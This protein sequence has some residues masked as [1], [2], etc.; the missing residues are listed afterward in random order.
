MAEMLINNV[1]QT[2][3]DPATAQTYT[4]DDWEIFAAGKWNGDAY[5][6]SD[7]DDIVQSFN[8]I[9]GKLKPYLKLGH[10]D[11]QKL[12]QK[13]GYPAAGWITGLK[14]VGEKLV[15]KVEGIPAKIYSLIQSKGYGRVSSE[16]FWNTTVEGKRYRRALKAVALLGA[17]TPE[18][19]VL[20]DFINLYTEIT[21]GELHAYHVLEEYKEVNEMD[22][23]KILEMDE[24]LKSYAAKISELETENK[25]LKE[26]CEKHQEAARVAEYAKRQTE[27][28]AYLDEKVAAG[29]ITPAQVNYYMAI[30]MNGAEIKSYT[31]KDGEIKGSSF[32]LVKNILDSSKAV[33]PMTGS[34]VSE[35][36]EQK[37]YSNANVESDDDKLHEE[38]LKYSKEYKVDYKTAFN[39]IAN[40][41]KE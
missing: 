8:E 20:D 25:Q 23:K 6:A 27:V 35:P 15:A 12:L 17:D 1:E 36:Q 28:A 18:V 9:G 22:E 14:R 26:E 11:K 13:E 21:D 30:A 3:P 2:K 33:V 41:G 34:T 4:V 7:L 29:I 10:D 31:S 24:Q 39:A 19:S 40:K 32:D 16:I 37:T 5:S 38:I